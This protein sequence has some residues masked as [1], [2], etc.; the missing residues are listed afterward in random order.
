M[1]PAFA[2]L[3]VSGMSQVDGDGFER[4]LQACQKYAAANG[5]E[6]TNV[7]REEGITGKSELDNRPALQSLIADLLS[8]GTRTVIIEKLDRLARKVIVQETILEDLQRRGI[9]I[10]SA[11]EPDLIDDDPTRTLI[12]QILGAFFEYERKMIVD[13]LKSARQRKKAQTGRCEGVKPYGTLDGE[14]ETLAQ[15]ME[16]A[17]THHSAEG[18]AL[19]LNHADYRTRSGGPWSPSVVRKIIKRETKNNVVPAKAS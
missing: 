5:Y 17:A 18:I 14:Q 15:I 19:I 8:N 1:T 13:K 12:R 3:R 11:C 4:Q 7:Y 2:Y 9:K 16:L 6:I 10:I